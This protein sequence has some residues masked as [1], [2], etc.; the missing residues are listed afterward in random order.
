ML[1]N[2]YLK[3]AYNMKPLCRQWKRYTWVQVKFDRQR[4]GDSEY[5][6]RSWQGKGTGE[7]QGTA[8]A[9]TAPLR[10]TEIK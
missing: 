1:K 5:A 6:V 2:N 3:M 8:A 7:V 9:G 4:S 10:E